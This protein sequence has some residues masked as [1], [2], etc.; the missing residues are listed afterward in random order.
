MLNYA[1]SAAEL[2]VFDAQTGM[3]VSHGLEAA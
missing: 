2:H 1:I 3:A